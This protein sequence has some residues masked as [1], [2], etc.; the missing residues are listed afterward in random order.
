MAQHAIG[1][2]YYYGIG[3]PMDQ[4]KGVGWYRMAA[5]QGNA[6]ALYALGSAYYYGSGVTRDPVEGLAWLYLANATGE[7]QVICDVAEQTLG[8]AAVEKAKLRSKEI[9]VSI[10]AG[11]P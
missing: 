6:D 11:T 3:L 9:G 2:A 4:E 5:E 8:L 10:K 1:A 7:H